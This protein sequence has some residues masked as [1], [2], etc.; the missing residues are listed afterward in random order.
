MLFSLN[1]TESKLE[2]TDKAR[3][4]LQVADKHDYIAL[5][6]TRIALK[7]AGHN[8]RYTDGQRRNGAEVA[9][10]SSV[11][12]Q[13]GRRQYWLQLDVMQVQNPVNASKII[14]LSARRLSAEFISVCASKVSGA[15]I[16]YIFVEF[17][18]VI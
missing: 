14:W 7:Q 8:A 16:A 4:C 6:C 12:A 5:Q 15:A 2:S 10:R 3:G 13:G 11:R 1:T 17:D 9:I 18:T